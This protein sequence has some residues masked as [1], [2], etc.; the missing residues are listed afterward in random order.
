M[1]RGGE[2]WRGGG[3]GASASRSAG[4]P[5]VRTS[6]APC[7]R[8]RCPSSSQAAPAGRGASVCGSG[9]A[10]E[11][12]PLLSPPCAVS[13]SPVSALSLAPSLSPALLLHL[14]VCVSCLRWGRRKV[15]GRRRGGDLREPAPEQVELGRAVQPRHRALHRCNSLSSP[16]R[17]GRQGRRRPPPAGLRRCRRPAGLAWRWS[18]L[19]TLPALAAL[20]APKRAQACWRP[21]RA[22]ARASPCGRRRR[23]RPQ[24]APWAAT[25]PGAMRT[26]RTTPYHELLNK[27]LHGREPPPA[28]GARR[29]ADR[30]ARRAGRIFVFW[31]SWGRRFVP[32]NKAFCGLFSENAAFY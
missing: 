2:E 13:P 16:H 25:C 27:L 10:R 23:W 9:V 5:A 4:P 1:R 3:P 8:P 12:S 32:Q 31:R 21:V 7:A 20:P 6:C 14:A 24:G 15:W 22:D 30:R 11:G 18:E 17:L 26:W 29:P 28:A 19:L